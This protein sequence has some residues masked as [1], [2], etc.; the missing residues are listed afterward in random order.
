ML[1]I[2]RLQAIAFTHAG[3]PRLDIPGL[4]QHVVCR[5]IERKD[6]IIFNKACVYPRR[7][8]KCGLRNTEKWKRPE[9]E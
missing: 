2:L 6:W 1:D 4:V 3:G 9:R 5:G 7:W 8:P